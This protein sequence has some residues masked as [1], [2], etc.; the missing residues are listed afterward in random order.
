MPDP[1]ARFVD[2]QRDSY[3]TALAELRSGAKRSHW[4]WYVFPQIAG[5][6]SSAMARTYAL[7]DLPEARAYLAHPVLGARLRE[8]VDALLEHRGGDIA[9]IL[10]GID[11]MKLRSSMTLFEIAANG[12][13]PRFA[14]IL[15][16]FYGGE[17]DPAT[18][19]LLG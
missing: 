18:L 5:L 7:A 16:S 12:A 17:R 4:M 1:L 10:G 19:R 14:A 3:A 6:G 2:A 11:A 9:A 13:E 8:S 15:D